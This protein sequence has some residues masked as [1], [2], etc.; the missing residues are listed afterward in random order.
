[1]GA[2]V[3]GT[4]RCSRV[5]LSRFDE[6]LTGQAIVNNIPVIRIGNISVSELFLNKSSKYRS[7][8]GGVDFTFHTSWVDK[9]I[10]N[11]YWAESIYIDFSLF[12]RKDV[13]FH[14]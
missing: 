4:P 13:V 5:P 10:S 3:G 1:M 6:G 7:L 12:S 2:N 8:W 9:I 11:Q 14:T